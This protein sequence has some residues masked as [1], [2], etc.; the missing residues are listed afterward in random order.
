[1]RHPA[2]PQRTLYR[3]AQRLYELR[4]ARV[5]REIVEEGDRVPHEALLECGAAAEEGLEQCDVL[6]Q[7][8]EVLWAEAAAWQ[9]E[10]GPVVPGEV[11][12]PTN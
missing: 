4:P 8:L 6:V 3:N 11:E 1:M 2:S 5:L 9:L 7:R 12:E 10:H